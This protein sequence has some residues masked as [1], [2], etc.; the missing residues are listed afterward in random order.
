LIDGCGK[1]KRG[2]TAPQMHRKKR[3]P[4]SF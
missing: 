1:K 2:D 4:K 3:N